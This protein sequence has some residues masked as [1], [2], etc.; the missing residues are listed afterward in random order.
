[1]NKTEIIADRRMYISYN[2]TTL[3]LIFQRYVLQNW[4]EMP[5]VQV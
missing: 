4:I 5:S 3:K 2:M 1:M